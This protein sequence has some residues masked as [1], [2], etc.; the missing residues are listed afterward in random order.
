MGHYDDA[1]A[2]EHEQEQKAR[3]ANLE[4]Q[5]QDLKDFLMWKP[6][7]VRTWSW[8]NKQDTLINKI[9]E[10]IQSQLYDLRHY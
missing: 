2:Y 10:D 9:I 1:Y 3:K 4:A 6:D 5:L 7:R 8:S